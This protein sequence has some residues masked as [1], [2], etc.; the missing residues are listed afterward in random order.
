MRMTLVH[1]TTATAAAI[2]ASALLLTACGGE[3][4]ASPA[5]WKTLHTKKVDVGYP[6][7]YKELPAGERSKNTDAEAVLTEDGTSTVRISVALDFAQT[8][9]LDM[10]VLVAEGVYEVGGTPKGE[11]DV[12]IPGAKEAR[13]VAHEFA[14]SGEDGTPAKGTPM[15]AVDVVGMDGSDRPWDV[16]VIAPK[17]KL[18][19]D[20]LKKIVNTIKVVTG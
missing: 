13:Q 16:R 12:K 18:S 14:S 17:G 20:E 2:A 19:P 10:A 8:S 9:R 3:K 5:G 11:K 1:R 6:D 7:G 15:T 4:Q